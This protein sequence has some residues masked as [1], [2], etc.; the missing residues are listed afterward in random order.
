MKRKWTKTK[1]RFEHCLEIPG[2]SGKLIDFLLVNDRVRIQSLNKSL[3]NF[4]CAPPYLANELHLRDH[5]CQEIA[6]ICSRFKRI[7]ILEIWV[8]KLHTEPE[9][10]GTFQLFNTSHLFSEDRMGVKLY[11]W[12]QKI[13]K[14]WILGSRGLMNHTFGLNPACSNYHKIVRHPENIH[15]RIPRKPWNQIEGLE[16]FLNTSS[17]AFDYDIFNEF[18]HLFPHIIFLDIRTK[19]LDFPDFSHMAR[20]TKL[21]YLIISG[22]YCCHLKLENF[23]KIP[24]EQLEHL[25]LRKCVF[26]NWKD[27]ALEILKRAKNLKY[28][29]GKAADYNL[30]A[31]PVRQSETVSRLFKKKHGHEIVICAE[32]D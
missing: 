17:I 29:Q 11:S 18:T 31:S 21:K 1:S 20:L 8:D 2:I 28:Y 26:L 27:I 3:Q 13:Q 7:T 24:M 12:V 14:I 32:D 22:A 15:P 16:S 23:K 30:R 19:N 5:E 10:D 25:H 9:E 4:D 6:D